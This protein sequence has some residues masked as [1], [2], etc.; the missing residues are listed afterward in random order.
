M[1][2]AVTALTAIPWFKTWRFPARHGGTPLSLDD[3]RG[4]FPFTWIMTGGTPI[5]GNHRFC[6]M[7]YQSVFCSRDELASAAVGAQ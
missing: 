1:T 4:K 6:F 3:L 7:E 2:Y 5:S